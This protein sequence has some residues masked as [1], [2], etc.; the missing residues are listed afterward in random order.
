[1]GNSVVKDFKAAK[2]GKGQFNGTEKDL[3]SPTTVIRRNATLLLRKEGE[4]CLY[5]NESTEDLHFKVIHTGNQ[6]VASDGEDFVLFVAR[7]YQKGS[8]KTTYIYKT[9]PIFK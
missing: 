9:S 6:F 5:V 1:M 4:S 7:S 3:I 8:Q 2:L